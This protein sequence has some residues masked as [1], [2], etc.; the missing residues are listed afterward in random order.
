MRIR[1]APAVILLLLLLL[2]ACAGPGGGGG[3]GS[4]LAG[5]TFL[6]SEVTGRTL[7]A[8][9]QL[10][11]AFPE[12]GK[13]S[14]HGGCNRLAGDA[15]FDVDRLKVSELSSTNLGCDKAR[16]EQDEWLMAFLKAGPRFALN[17]DELVL[18]GDKETIKFVDRKVARPDKPLQGTR[19]VVESLLDGQTAGSVPQG[20]Q[21]FLRFDG[22]T[23]TGSDG[24][25][26]LSGKAIQGPSTIA[27]SEIATTR[28]AC[29][30]DLAA[31]SAA[32]LATLAGEV[33]FKID[34]DVL[35]LRSPNGKGL[36]ARGS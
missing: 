16:H 18:T 26:Q 7:A 5:R 1:S 30:D 11:L 29:A 36:I 20:T 19:W 24:C 12:G 6:S 15:G 28:K 27:F 21:A 31:L 35:E 34:S 4:R 13:L 22:D 8:G 33:T 9:T 17:G 25:N 2:S 14:L 23:F 32:V 3:E 10:Q